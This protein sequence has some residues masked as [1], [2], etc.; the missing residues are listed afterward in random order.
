MTYK[1]GLRKE[2]LLAL[3]KNSFIYKRF[4]FFFLLPRIIIINRALIYD[5]KSKRI[6][7][8]STKTHNTRYVYLSLRCAIFTYFMLKDLKEN[9]RVFKIHPHVLT[10]D[11]HKVIKNEKNL[12]KRQKIRFEDLRHIHTSYILSKAKNKAIVLKAMQERLRSQKHSNYF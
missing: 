10:T 12:M 5:K 6:V 4:L 7:I 9:E 1:H 11:F 2:E 3:E 8:K